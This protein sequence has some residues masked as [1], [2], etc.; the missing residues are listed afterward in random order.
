MKQKKPMNVLRGLKLFIRPSDTFC[1]R[2]NEQL[3]LLWKQK[4]SDFKGWVWKVYNII[5]HL[6][7]SYHKYSWFFLLE[8][9]AATKLK[10]RHP[11]IELGFGTLT[12]NLTRQWVI[13]D[14]LGFS[15]TFK[16]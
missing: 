16:V 5:N 1:N 10:W 3:P 13:I 2:D 7:V 12:K 6:V 9:V 15:N 4:H 8:R 14:K 11:T